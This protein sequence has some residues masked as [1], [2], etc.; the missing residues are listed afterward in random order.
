MTWSDRW[1]AL[2]ARIEGLIAAAQFIVPALQQDNGDGCGIVREWIAPE[3]EKITAEMDEFRKMSANDLPQA[4][5]VVLDKFCENF[6]FTIGFQSADPKLAPIAALITFRSEFE[7]LIRDNEIESCNRVEVAFEHLRRMIA[8]D[9]QIRQKWKKAF[10]S[11]EPA[12]ERLGAIHLLS[13]GIFAFKIVGGDSA[14]DLAFNEPID[15]R[16][17]IIRHAARTI[18]LTEWKRIIE[19]TGDKKA[20]EA[21]K[22]TVQYAGGVLGDTVLERTRYIVLVSERQIA[23]VQDLE[24]DGIKFRHVHIAVDPLPPSRAARQPR[25][26]SASAQ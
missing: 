2:S 18:V 10:K 24:A 20:V 13:H 19:P 1:H 11:N 16:S 21:R 23:Q 3:L 12:C 17:H 9:E 25:K 22:Q 26:R 5:M 7:F 14:T 6:P 8:V 4:A 15:D